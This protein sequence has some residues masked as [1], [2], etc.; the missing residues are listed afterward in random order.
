MRSPQQAADA[1]KLIDQFLEEDLKNKG[2]R[3]CDTYMYL[4]YK[5]RKDLEQ[6]EQNALPFTIEDHLRAMVYSM[7]SS[8]VPWSKISKCVDSDSKRLTEVDE[9]FF[10]YCPTLLK[11]SCPGVLASALKNKG[12]SG[13]RRREQ[14]CALVK[15]NLPKLCNFKK[16]GNGR[17][18]CYYRQLEK[19]TGGIKGLVHSLADTNSPNK[20]KQMGIPLVTEYL[21]NV[22]YDIAKPD[23]HIRRILGKNHL[24]CSNDEIVS[25]DEA[26]DIVE[27]IADELGEN[28]PQQRVDYALWAYCAKNYGEFCKKKI[29]KANC[30]I[31]VI[32]Q[33][34]QKGEVSK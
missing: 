26:I 1:V 13:W 30:E 3:W 24:Y 2:Q 12:Y 31:C 29:S 17:I 4:Q 23:R 9:I 19:E 16:W 11:K 8:S 6:G 18:D 33:Y 15:T 27:S 21:R 28:W 25:F 22:G 32:K 7:L 10:G 14:M 34:C 5:R 20:L